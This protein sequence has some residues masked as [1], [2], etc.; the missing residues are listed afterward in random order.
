MQTEDDRIFSGIVAIA[1]LHFNIYSDIVVVV[2]LHASAML[3]VNFLSP[4]LH[5]PAAMNGDSWCTFD[6]WVESPSF[7]VSVCQIH[8]GGDVVRI[9]IW[10][11]FP[12]MTL[13]FCHCLM[14]TGEVLVV[15]SPSSTMSTLLFFMSAQ[16]PYW[17]S[18]HLVVEFAHPS[19]SGVAILYQ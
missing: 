18:G 5:R 7:P 9:N 11:W 19:V 12:T 10:L 16:V 3:H 4:K 1:L 8:P 2:L 6:A 15:D 17:M 13:Q 14:Y